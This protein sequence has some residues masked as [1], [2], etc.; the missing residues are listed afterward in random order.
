MS[1]AELTEEI[2]QSALVA[3]AAAE[4]KEDGRDFLGLS[5]ADRERYVKRFRAGVASMIEVIDPPAPISLEEV[6]A[7]LVV[8]EERQ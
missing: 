6:L 1:R 4:A 3:G 2:F 5:R 7:G 8:G